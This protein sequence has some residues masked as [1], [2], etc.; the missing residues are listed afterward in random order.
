MIGGAAPEKAG[1]TVGLLLNDSEARGDGRGT[2]RVGRTEDGDDG[3]ADGSSNVHGARIVAEEEM[4]LGEKGGKVGDGRFAGEIDGCASQVIGD[5]G[6][7]GSFGG[8]AEEEDVRVRL[9]DSS[10]EGC[11]ETIRG[12]AFCRTVRGA[13]ANGDAHG[14][15]A[16]ASFEESERGAL[17]RGVGDLEGDVRVV[18]ERIDPAGATE[19]FEV[20]KLFVRRNF[21]GFGNRNGPGEEEAARIASVPDSL[22]DMGVPGEPGGI[23]SVLE[24]ESHVQIASTQIF[25]QQFPAPKATMLRLWIVMDEFVAEGLVFVNIRDIGTRDDR[26][27]RM[28][29]LGANS[30]ERGESHDGVAYPI[31]SSNQN[32]HATCFSRGIFAWS[33]VRN[34]DSFAICRSMTAK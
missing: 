25:D 33:R 3:K 29:K 12:P 17:A 21:A 10:I 14:V 27:V 30:S 11:S 19:E 4:A 20:I 16:R 24:K 22:W 18:G 34:E 2:V 23:E 1:T 6:R 31:R 15:G 32:F 26:D 7:N 9:R 8:R 5:G 28:A 13:C